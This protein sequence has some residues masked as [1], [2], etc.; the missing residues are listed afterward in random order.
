VSVTLNQ[1]MKALRCGAQLHA[2]YLA[3]CLQWAAPR[4]LQTVRGTTADNISSSCPFSEAERWD[5]DLQTKL[6]ID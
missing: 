2:E 5:F 1:D 3:R 6:R 4:L